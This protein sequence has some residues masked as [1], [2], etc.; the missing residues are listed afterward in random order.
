MSVAWRTYFRI[1]YRLLRLL[2]PLIRLAW[3]GLGPWLASVV[4]LRVA[5]RRSGRERRLLLTGLRLDGRL[6]VGHPNGAAAWTR[7]LDAATVAAVIGRDGAATTVR[8]I[9][10]RPG[11]ERTRVIRSTARLQP[12]PGGLVYRAARGHILRVGVYYRLEPLPD[13]AAEPEQQEP[14]PG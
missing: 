12:F 10:L 1:Q 14:Y 13:P 9:G 4:E 3:L 7:N 2:D 6:Y 8:A 5:G 11:D